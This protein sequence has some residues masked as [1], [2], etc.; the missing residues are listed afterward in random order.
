MQFILENWVRNIGA[1][2]TKLQGKVYEIETD[3]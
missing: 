3:Q 1:G 2:K